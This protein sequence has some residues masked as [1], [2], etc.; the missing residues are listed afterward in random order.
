[1]ST[2]TYL[3]F[4]A[5]VTVAMAAASAWAYTAAPQ[6]VQIPV[7]WNLAGEAVSFRSKDVVLIAPPVIAAVLS[8]VLALMTRGAIDVRG[9]MLRAVWLGGLFSLAA[10]HTFLVLGA[11]GLVHAFGNYTALF[12]AVFLTVI[13]NYLTKRGFGASAPAGLLAGERSRRWLGRSL[14]VTGG[15]T[16]VSWFIWPG[17]VSE[18]VLVAGGLGSVLIAIIAGTRPAPL[19][20]NGNEV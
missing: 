2:R 5:L 6:I 13:G 1:M 10:V 20:R 16:I 17:A 12:P 8:L 7:H 15:A 19:E 18:L 4:S 9:K 3:I 11:A 14:V